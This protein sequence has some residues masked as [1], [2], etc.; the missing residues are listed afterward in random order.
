MRALQPYQSFQQRTS[1]V[2]DSL[3]AMLEEMASRGECAHILGAEPQTEALL[4]WIGPAGKV[5]TAA[6]DTKE[7]RERERIGGKGTSY[8]F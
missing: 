7:A 3:V 5:I 4:D 6:V 8:Y 2:R 1:V